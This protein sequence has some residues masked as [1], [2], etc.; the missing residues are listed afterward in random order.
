[1]GSDLWVS[2]TAQVDLRG[3]LERSEGFVNWTTDWLLELDPRNPAALEVELDP[4]L[5]LINVLGNEV[6]GYRIVPS[7]TP[8]RVVVT[9][10][11][12][13][14][15]AT[16]VRFLAHARVPT[17]GRWSVPSIRPLSANWTGGTT[18]VLL[19]PYH[20]VAGCVEKAGRRVFGASGESPR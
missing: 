10:G 4:G 7:L 12:E 1:P 8:E 9:L 5:E 6:R 14:K 15:R 2:G 17:E 11:G 20:V 13:L 19:D 3:S 18:T 16:E